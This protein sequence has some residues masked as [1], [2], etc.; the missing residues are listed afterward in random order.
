MSDV[1][2]LDNNATTRPVPEVIE[3][4][5]EALETWWQNPSSVHRAGQQVR[6][7]V[8]LARERIVRLIGCRDRELVLTSG[9]TEAANM[10]IAGMLAARP[11]RATIVTSR[12]EHSAVRECAERLGERG[13]RVIWAEHDPNGLIDLN[14]LSEL[15][16]RESEQIAVVSIMWAN[17]ETGI[18]QPIREIGELCRERGVRFHCDATQWVGKMP[19]DVSDMPVDLLSFAGHKFHGPKGVGGLYI[20]RG[21]RVPAMIIGG[22]QERERR[23]GTENVPGILGLGA[24][25]ESAAKWL[26]DDGPARQA[27]LR[28]RL[29]TAVTTAVEH[30]QINGAAAPRLWNTTN[31]GFARLEA[32]AI[33]LLLSERGVYA[34]AGAACSSGSLDPSPVLLAMGIPPEIAHGSVRFSISRETTA[35]EID[36]A[37]EIIPAVIGRLYGSMAAL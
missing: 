11:D 21:V 19:C 26:A 33:L 1:I 8:E 32:E 15:L 17:N 18:V 6:Q 24:A 9:G 10:A 16:A 28:D 35:A 27:A 22:P 13:I 12:L 7:Q 36:R 30:A 5:R 25:A 3:A 29:E 34:S 31:I 37:A 20:R 2:Y 23:G 14:Q 4:M